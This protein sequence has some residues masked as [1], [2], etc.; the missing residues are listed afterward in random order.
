[1]DYYNIY[2]NNYVHALSQRRKLYK[3][4]LELLDYW[5]TTIGEITN[6]LSI[7][8][9][10]Q[11]NINYQQGMRR[12]CSLTVIDVDKKYQPS[13]NSWFWYN[14]KFK[15]YLGIA[16]N[17]DVY[18]W[19]QG[20]F[21]TTSA[22]VSQNTVNIQAVDKFGMIDGTIK[23]GMV[24]TT[25]TAPAKTNIR[26]LLLDTLMLD[27]GNN[28][29][30]DPIEPIVDTKFRFKTLQSEIAI[31][32]GSYIGELFTELATSYS[33]DVYYDHTGKLIFSSLY[34]ASRVSGYKYLAPQWTYKDT[35]AYYC[36]V[37]T[38]YEFD[39]IN[40]VTVYTNTSTMENVSYMAYNTNPLS[41]L[42][43]EYVGLRRMESQE[44]PFVDVEQDEMKDL[45]RQHAQYLLLKNSII[46]MSKTFNSPIIPH[47][48]VNKTI[49]I[50]DSQDNNRVDLY[51]VQSISIPLGA[52][53]MSVTAC[54]V[55]WLPDDADIE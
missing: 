10:G 5:E 31:S 38:T 44:I 35:D 24:E 20:V 25:Y 30:I 39:G 45:C 4:K 34:D 41:P 37:T 21:F 48:D 54:N 2:D 46:G 9:K 28:K 12:S 29:P 53:E 47:M 7:T 17:D 40:C 43:V 52:E 3:I 16:Y 19:S 1:M 13:E 55:Q 50:E 22:T 42:R 33:A 32:E 36:G 8:S 18:W 15:L 23:I 6:D 11:I 49:A 26:S 51:V 14:R 27:I